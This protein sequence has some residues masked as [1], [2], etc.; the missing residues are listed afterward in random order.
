MDY[1]KISLAKDLGDNLVEG[2]TISIVGIYINRSQ[3]VRMCN[4]P[5]Q[6]LEELAKRKNIDSI[7]FD[8][9][10]LCTP[11]RSSVL[12]AMPSDLAEYFCNCIFLW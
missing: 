8:R 2:D 5:T 4:E 7:I 11:C 9:L 12:S 3:L 1:N 6:K 10:F